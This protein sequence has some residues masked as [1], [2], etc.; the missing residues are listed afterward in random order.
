[1]NTYY[2]ELY[3][4]G[5]LTDEIIEV[6]NEQD[7]VKDIYFES[8]PNKL[9]NSIFV[10]VEFTDEQDNDIEYFEEVIDNIENAYYN[11]DTIYDNYNEYDLMEW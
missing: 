8:N 6:L 9:H 11:I 5:E 7:H 2:I 1:M 4:F 3:T 10:K